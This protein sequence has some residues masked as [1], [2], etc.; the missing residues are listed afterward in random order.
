MIKITQVRS[1]V[2]PEFVTMGSAPSLTPRRR[3]APENQAIGRTGILFLWRKGNGRCLIPSPSS[4]HTVIP[5]Q[6]GIFSTNALKIP[7]SAGMT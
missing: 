4:L 1:F 3:S 7:A 6:A 5:A 2:N